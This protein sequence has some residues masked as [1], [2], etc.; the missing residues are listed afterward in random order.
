[1]GEEFVPG[2]SQRVLLSN[3]KIIVPILEIKTVGT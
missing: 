3:N 2:R 1:M